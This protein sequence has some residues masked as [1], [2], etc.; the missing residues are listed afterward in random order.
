[1]VASEFAVEATLQ[2]HRFLIS[3]RE[4]RPH[5]RVEAESPRDAVHVERPA[6][7][8]RLIVINES[9]E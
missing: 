6:A 3:K 2:L 7:P 8:K 1:M 5:G 4:T 9:L